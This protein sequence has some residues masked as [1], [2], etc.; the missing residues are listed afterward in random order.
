MKKIVSICVAFIL[1]T[2][3]NIT[4]AQSIKGSGNVDIYVTDELKLTNSG[5]GN[6]YYEGGAA[7]T[8]INSHG[9]GKIKKK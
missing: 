2:I 6:I 4:N 5:V 7:I 8:D 1:L 9:I 3:I